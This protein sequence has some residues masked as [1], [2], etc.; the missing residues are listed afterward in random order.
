MNPTPTQGHSASQQTSR[1]PEFLATQGWA[2]ISA[3]RVV[4][5]LA[6]LA[7]ALLAIG[8]LADWELLRLAVQQ[9]RGQPWLLAVLVAA[10]TGA[11]MLRAIAWRAL[12]SGCIGIYQ[13]FVSVQCRLMVNHLT[14]VNMGE[15]AR[16]VLATRYGMPIVEAL[17]TTTVA[18][19]IDF[20]TLLGIAAVVGAAVSLSIGSPLWRE[21]LAT[22]LSLVNEVLD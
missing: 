11:L 12:S 8:F 15:I 18:R 2:S 10:C 22:G 3:L 1:L 13:L 20:A 19:Y 14:P 9:L 4:A 5:S 6:L 21:R 16:P 7:L 17:I